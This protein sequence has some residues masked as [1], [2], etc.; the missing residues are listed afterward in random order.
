MVELS[1]G[2]HF[3]P[4][5]KRN[6]PISNS[7]VPLV[8]NL[9]VPEIDDMVFESDEKLLEACEQAINQLND[10]DYVGKY[11]YILRR[12]TYERKLFE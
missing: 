7:S 2:S 10:S 12:Y 9:S 4:G 8:A 3:I 5:K 6:T 1:L 11:S